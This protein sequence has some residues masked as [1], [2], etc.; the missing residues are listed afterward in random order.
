MPQ[1]DHR[2][3]L[4]EQL[5]RLAHVREQIATARKGMHERA[6]KMHDA[7]R[8]PIDVANDVLTRSPN[9]LAL[10]AQKKLLYDRARCAAIADTVDASDLTHEDPVFGGPGKR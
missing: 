8:R 5:A 6:G 1:P 9:V 10:R 3:A 4:L 2:Q 7:M